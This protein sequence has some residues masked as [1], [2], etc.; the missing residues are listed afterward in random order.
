M[1]SASGGARLQ[2]VPPQQRLRSLRRQLWLERVVF[3]PIIVGL[4]VL[5]VKQ[6]QGRFAYEISVGGRSVALVASG[7]D[8][9]RIVQ[10]VRHELVPDVPRQA[11]Y[12]PPVSVA[13]IPRGDRP[14]LPFE[15]AR[16][17][18]RRDARLYAPGA[19][20]MVEG[21]P[22]AAL[23]TVE[24][25]RGCIARVQATYGSGR[26]WIKEHWEIREINM[27][28]RKRL[29]VEQAQQVLTS[30]ARVE[31]Y[32]VGRNES[33][34]SIART[35]GISVAALKRANQGVDLAALRPG[36]TI[37]IGTGAPPLSVTTVRTQTHVEKI[38]YR[39][40]TITEPDLR[41]GAK[42][43]IQPGLPGERQVVEQVTLENGKETGRRLIKTQITRQ[44]IPQRVAV[45]R[46]Q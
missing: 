26:T 32:R 29:T 43:I 21:R 8:A 38:P 9:D 15:Q 30:P 37:R 16:K 11:S 36:I 40:E 14:V 28:S 1:P 7:G 13:R 42:R 27:E 22:A 10:G 31:I 17:Q 20:I 12:N 34:W 4:L 25:A 23:R 6:E 24:D 19:V 41:P 18:F 35:H 45:G 5:L 3:V 33:A 46:E 2:P 39:T 44:P